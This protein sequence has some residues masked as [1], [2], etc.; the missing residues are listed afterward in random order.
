MSLALWPWVWDLC[1]NRG[2]RRC[3]LSLKIHLLPFS[4]KQEMRGHG[5]SPSLEAHSHSTCLVLPRTWMLSS[6]F[7]S[8]SAPTSLK[9][10]PGVLPGQYCCGESFAECPDLGGLELWW[11]CVFMSFMICYVSYPC[12]SLHPARIKPLRGQRLVQS[13]QVDPMMFYCPPNGMAV[14]ILWIAVGLWTLLYPAA[15]V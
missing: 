15:F 1:S 2:W 10:N 3:C 13:G 4:W 6:S 9:A 11:C 8:P 12:A 14:I 7:H 5:G